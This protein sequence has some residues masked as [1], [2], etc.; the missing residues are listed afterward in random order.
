MCACVCGFTSMVCFF[1][2]F[3]YVLARVCACVVGVYVRARM[4][5]CLHACMGAWCVCVIVRCSIITL[6]V[7]KTVWFPLYILVSNFRVFCLVVSIFPC[8]I[9]FHFFLFRQSAVQCS[10]DLTWLVIL[11]K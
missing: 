4:C 6:L 9:I 8:S 11:T 2:L 10:R 3:V 7:P 5:V 1:C